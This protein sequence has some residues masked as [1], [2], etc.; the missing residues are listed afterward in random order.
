[1]RNLFVGCAIVAL[2]S[3]A[4]SAQ[5][6]TSTIRGTVTSGN[7]P[8]AGATVTV[9][10]VPSGTR[11]VTTSDRAGNYSASGLRP[12]GPFTVT[13]AAPGFADSQVTDIATVIS[14]PFEL[15]V[16]LQPQGQEIVVSANKVRGARIVSEGP[17]TVLNADQISKIASVNRDIR[18]L[19]RR[20][21]FA[22]LDT[23]S[24]TGRNVS[25]A[26]QNP[27][28]NRFTIDGVPITDNFGLNSD[29]L[30]SRRGPVPLDSIAQFETKVAPFDIREGF[31]QGGVVNAILKSGT[32]QFHGT[33]FY[34]YNSDKLVGDRTK[35]Y[36]TAPD[37]RI[38]QPKFKSQDY[39]VELSGPIVKDKI[40][41]MI[42]GERVR[43]A[44]PLPYGTTDDNAG[45]PV[46][47]LSSATV[48]SIVNI[49]KSKYGYDAG[50]IVRNNGDKDD[51]LVGKIDVNLADGQRLALTGI[52]TKDSLTSLTNTSPTILSLSSNAY[53]KPNRVFGGVAQLNSDW[54]SQFS[55]EARILYKDYKSGQIPLTGYA[56]SFQ[57][58]TD[59]TSDIAPGTS[60]STG[61]SLSCAASQVQIGPGGPS[62]ANIL[63]SKT[64]GGSLL[65]RLHL[66]DHN[67]RQ[68]IDVT[69]VNIFNEFVNNALGTYYFDSIA[70]FA[71]GNAQQLSYQNAVPSLD[72]VDAAA[73][74]SYQTYTFGLQDDWRVNGKLN[75]TYGV[76]YDLFGGSSRPASNANFLARYGFP[77]NYYVSGRGLLQPR[78]GFNYSPTHRLSIK[79]GGGIFGGGTPDVYV[80][81]S[82]SQSGVL[83]NSLTA[84]ETD[85]GLYQING[86]TVGTAAGQAILNGINI[87]SVAAA[88]N[89]ALNSATVSKTTSVNAIS[90]NFKIPS[91]WRATLSGTYDLDL[92]PLGDHW[93][94]GG[95]LLFSKVRNQ[96][97]YTDIRSVPV[98]GSF[99]P[100]G[101]QRYQNISGNNGDTNAD[102]LLTDTHKGRSWVAVARFD[103][104]WDFGLDVNGSF[105]YQNVK[106]QSALTS[107]QASSLYYNNAMSDPN[108][109][110]YGHSN[111]EVRYSF[112]YNVSYEHAFFGDYK[113]RIDIFG[114]T[115]IGSP[116]S[117]TF[118]DAS[119]GRSAVFGTT[120]SS[121]SSFNSSQSRYLFYVPTSASDPKVL[122]A[123]AA[124][125]TAI[126]NLIDSTGLS[127]YRGK[128][129][130]RNAFNSKWFTKLDI[131]LE[132]QLPTFVGRSHISIFA[133]IENFT[134]L[135][136]HKWGQQLRSFFPYYKAVAKVSCVAQGTNACAQYLYS[137]PT[138]AATLADQLITANG[139]S[140][141]SVR[142]GARLT[143]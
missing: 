105:T 16:E 129:A 135:L 108:T 50:G 22:N 79:G 117:Y 20:D 136:N 4:A 125:Q 6:T 19:M 63:T 127:K 41:F 122:Y 59:G 5:E 120:Q 123:D 140:L 38:V 92:G 99:T 90:P 12:G 133:D 56:S 97:F 138:P 73:R 62:Q 101:R 95:D 93:T 72:P 132:Q 42:S 124:T 77:N 106:D 141:Y 27:R 69:S 96:A 28:F 48:A 26:G 64:W 67:I 61:K 18:D 51:R 68:L 100:D 17:S 55:T 54:S 11:T 47:G 15:P 113:T 85:G 112:K 53:T 102:F 39:G 24:S 32:N 21:P 103:K 143:F 110:A 36:V 94:V 88:A 3:G 8:V 115:R 114:E 30:P 118:D 43:A 121:T 91:Q 25:F 34:T 126:N 82:F 58:C 65:S 142:I 49:A 66:G 137:S 78:I 45:S 116:Y 109:A 71:A 29:G 1:M 130:P 83:S 86:S 35:D 128:I 107:S 9:V 10:H 40:F 98:A 84:R 75:V 37:G 80:G 7:A 23:S 81:N 44:A 46:T 131:H 13:I 74:F 134:N 76:R 139:S 70:D 119:G 89:T 60:T 2:V 52:Y 87:N 31:F 104:A 14:Q 33:G 57:V 111:D